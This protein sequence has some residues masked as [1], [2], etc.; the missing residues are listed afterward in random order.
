MTSQPHVL[1]LITRLNIG[2]PARQALL[3]SKA[4]RDE[5]TTTLAAGRPQANEGELSDPDVPVTSVPLVRPLRPHIDVAAVLAVRR[6]LRSTGAALMHTHMA[7][8][9]T[10]GRIAA[11]RGRSGPRTVHTFHGHVLDGY[12][13]GPV[14]RAF[15]AVERRLA[16]ATDVLIAVSPEI[17]DQLLDLGIGRAAQYEVIPLGFD[18]S[19]FLDVTAP[20]GALRKDLGIGHDVPLVGVLGRLAPI[21]DHATLIDAIAALDGVH[22]AILGEGET[23]DA[24]RNKVDEAGLRS[25]VHFVGWRHDVA[26]AI[27]DMDVV[28][29]S[30]RNE[31]SPVS[32]IEALATARPVVSTDV[33]GV[34]SVVRDGVTGYLT[35]PG[36]A[37]G[38]AARLGEL[39]GDAELRRRMG[40]EGRRDVRDRYAS[41]RLVSDIRELYRELVG[42]K[43]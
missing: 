28:A 26:G 18:L 5:F 33:G 13:T 11:G 34:R 8:A 14:Q 23:S 25:R 41:E 9:G 35:R 40:D 31:G 38:L 2:G 24:L 43:R 17:R 30:S 29:L 19:T 37:A 3:L 21:K 16:R 39:L 32:L 22:L 20:S 7:K 27:G 15:V 1:R 42:R 10:V 6:L 36:D 4:L 12:F